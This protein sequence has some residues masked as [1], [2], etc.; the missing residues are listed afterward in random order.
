MFIHKYTATSKQDLGACI[1]RPDHR[2]NEQV[3]IN[4]WI[5]YLLSEMKTI[6]L[7]FYSEGTNNSFYLLEIHN[8]HEKSRQFP[9]HFAA[10]ACEA[11]LS[12]A[13]H[14]RHATTPPL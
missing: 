4:I 2:F 14:G 11:T 12:A 8:P 5:L 10:S 7:A 13:H 9:N 3:F 1:F 6:R